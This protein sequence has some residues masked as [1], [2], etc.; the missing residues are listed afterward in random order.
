[1]ALTYQDRLYLIFGIQTQYRTSE[2]IRA[3]AELYLKNKTRARIGDFL[4]F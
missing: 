4:F 1:M 2:Q 3:I